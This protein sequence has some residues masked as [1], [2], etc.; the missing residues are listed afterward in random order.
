MRR[1]ASGGGFLA[2]EANSGGGTMRAAALALTLLAVAA[3]PGASSAAMLFAAGTGLGAYGH[4]SNSGDFVCPTAAVT[5]T[6][7]KAGA[8][9]VLQASGVPP[10][11]GQTAEDFAN[12]VMPCSLG[13]FVAFGITD[14]TGSAEQGYEAYRVTDYG[15]LAGITTEWLRISPVIY[16]PV[17]V[18][19]QAETVGGPA[20]SHWWVE[21]D[22][23]RA[24]AV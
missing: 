24:A 8:L 2:R 6:H 11:F 13:T 15:T 14:F 9:L 18:S 4:H 21:A 10:T 16:Q 19:Y 12:H 7:Q 20:P 23:V 5:F 3:L 22:M 1:D 17:H